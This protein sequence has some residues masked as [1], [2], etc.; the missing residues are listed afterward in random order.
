MLETPTRRGLITGLGA[1]FLAAPA[2]VR[3]SSL[4]P[5]SSK[6]LGIDPL[7]REWTAVGPDGKILQ[8]WLLKVQYRIIGAIEAAED[9][10]ITVSA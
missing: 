3:A 7:W 4:M 5:V 8:Q 1:L 9:Q 2:I 10:T 6:N